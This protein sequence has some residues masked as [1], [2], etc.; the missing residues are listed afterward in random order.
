VNIV[1][2]LIY[3]AACEILAGGVL[4]T[5]EAWAICNAVEHP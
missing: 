4:G 1:E 2:W 3:A 5:K